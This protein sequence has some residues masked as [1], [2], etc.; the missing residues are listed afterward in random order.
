[1]LEYW[2]ERE[3]VIMENK[4]NGLEF[5]SDELKRDKEFLLYAFGKADGKP[6]NFFTDITNCFIIELNGKKYIAEKREDSFSGMFSCVYFDVLDN[7]RIIYKYQKEI[8]Y[9][10]ME[11]IKN[12]FG[13]SVDG[14][15][16]LDV[17]PELAS[18]E[19]KKVPRIMLEKIFN[20]MNVQNKLRERVKK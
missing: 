2:K 7:Y 3:M 20:E 10:G 8:I 14:E 4:K 6:T 19:D 5:L 11:K 12:P 18:Y 15:P 16:I 17:Y 9:N 1:M 13:E